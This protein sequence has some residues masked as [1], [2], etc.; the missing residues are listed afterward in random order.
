MA[1]ESPASGSSGSTSAKQRFASIASAAVSVAQAARASLVSSSPSLLRQASERNSLTVSYASSSSS[2][3][4]P[5][6]AAPQPTQQTQQQTATESL[7]KEAKDKAKV[8][9]KKHK[10]KQKSPKATP[11]SN[12]G[13]PAQ[14]TTAA[15]TSPRDVDDTKIE[16]VDEKLLFGS[17]IPGGSNSSG[18]PVLG[19][20][21]YNMIAQVMPSDDPLDS[22]NFNP[23]EYINNLFPNEQS[24]VDIDLALSR[25][26]VKM[27]RTED[28]ILRE[29]RHQ[30]Y[31]GE[32]G[33]KDLADAKNSIHELFAKINDIKRKAEQSEIMVQ[34]ICR[35]IKS[36]DYAKKH[37]TTTITSLKRLHMFV[38]GVD[39]LE[40]MASKRQYREVGNLL[41]AINE[42]ASHFHQ[43]RQV[44]KIVH[45]T[46]RTEQIKKDLHQQIF[47]DFTGL[48]RQPIANSMNLADACFVIDALG[49]DVQKEFVSWFCNQHLS[50][51][52]QTFEFGTDT[53][54]LEYTERR[55]LWLKRELVFFDEQLANIFPRG[56]AVDELLCL[57]FCE[58]TRQ[59]IS[60]TLEAISATLSADVLTAVLRKTL[61]FER[62]LC[63]RFISRL[64]KIDT[65]ET[66][67]PSV[68]MTLMV[69]DLDDE[70]DA[71]G[72]GG[73][74]GA[75]NPNSAEAIKHRLRKFQRR[76]ALKR[77][78]E[79]KSAGLT[80]GIGGLTPRGSGAE[81]P[82]NPFKRAISQAF[83][84]YLTIYIT[85]QDK[86]MADELDKI[87]R[88]ETW[89]VE[90]EDNKV[91][92]SS[93]DLVCF[94]GAVMNQ[95]QLLSNSQ[96]YFELYKL[97]KKYLKRYCHIL[98]SKLPTASTSGG[99]VRVTDRQERTIL[100]I[101]NTADYWTDRVFRLADKM[102]GI[103]D[104]AF[105]QEIDFTPEKEEFEGLLARGMRTLVAGLEGRLATA[106]VNMTKMPWNSWQSVGDQSEYVNQ[107]STYLSQSVPTY[108]AWLK[109]LH[110]R[111]FCDSF[112]E[113]FIPKLAEN[114]YKCR[115][116]SEV[117]AEQLL[118][119][120]TSI[121]TILI[122]M[123]VMAKGGGGDH[124]KRYVKYVNKAI[125]KVEVLL[126]L[127]ITPPES[128][129]ET[130]Q[131]LVKGG[132][133]AELQRIMELKGMKK[134]ENFL[135]S[136]LDQY[137]TFT[138]KKK[139]K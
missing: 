41:E 116:I 78:M 58:L 101:I 10:E 69:E 4:G 134:D 110:F 34:E 30:S 51:Y 115:Q 47:K 133:E 103:I 63:M 67:T 106:L 53:S 24:L 109:D 127:V 39:Q 80:A 12:K 88:E 65:T 70:K 35:D 93:T 31:D 60:D 85:Q 82:P 117:G 68:D 9:E 131:A 49:P 54:K 50:D 118:L 107:I 52:L 28:I 1:S 48:G 14:S 36:L 44:P 40:V 75:S 136:L 126:K 17:S 33:Q 79:E 95:T 89:D 108:A 61:D 66:N 74:V 46:E 91:L 55:F 62:E 15:S 16:S 29:V 132:S 21:V 72:E 100:L 6:P 128:L 98:E 77:E 73:E 76:L 102:K 3:V 19:G 104:P 25:L 123:P 26:R 105:A 59:Q 2:S 139:D 57:K 90:D 119:D 94:F 81:A 114:I 43:Y 32:K 8:K 87:V 121:K 130:Y 18:R 97:F 92:S 125:G 83:D 137:S 56:W 38:T 7:K 138:R 27:K 135:T 23:I 111:F 20:D 113:S 5:I 11:E 122:E 129:V 37:L 13:E 112:V 99:E 22:P 124:P 45:L 120:M 86:R 71:A 96:P 64:P 84:P 42:L